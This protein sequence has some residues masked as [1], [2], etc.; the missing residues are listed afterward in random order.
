MIWHKIC[1][2]RGFLIIFLT[3]VCFLDIAVSYYL[4]K[5]FRLP[6]LLLFGYLINAI[7]PE[8]SLLAV[9]PAIYF[10]CFCLMYFSWEDFC[11]EKRFFALRLITIS[12]FLLLSWRFTALI[13]NI[14]KIP[15]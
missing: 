10:L 13:L 14:S 12:Y 8:Q 11:K 4:I 3:C 2:I 5:S 6:E 1:R 15:Y 9:I 7:G